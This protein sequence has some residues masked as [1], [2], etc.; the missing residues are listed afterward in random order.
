MKSIKVMME[1]VLAKH[2]VAVSPETQKVLL[3][4]RLVLPKVPW[5]DDGK[6]KVHTPLLFMMP[7]GPVL[8]GLC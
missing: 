5:M 4:N 2:S 8:M 7:G 3:S 1:K 6:M